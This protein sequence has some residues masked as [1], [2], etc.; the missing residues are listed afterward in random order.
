MPRIGSLR[1]DRDVEGLIRVLENGEDLDA[2]AAAESL[3]DLHALQAVPALMAALEGGPYVQYG[4]AEALGKLGD[5]RAVPALISV[6]ARGDYANAV[7]A[8]ALGLLGDPSA[9]APIAEALAGSGSADRARMAKALAALDARD[10]LLRIAADDGD[11]SGML[12]RWPAAMELA[13]LGDARVVDVL[14][15]MPM[16]VEE[17]EI[18]A[19]DVLGRL[20]DNRGLPF[21]L[22]RAGSVTQVVTV[23]LS[24]P[25]SEK[26]TW[27]QS[28][29]LRLAAVE[30]LGQIICRSAFPL[31]SALGSTG[32]ATM[33]PT[34]DCSAADAD[35]GGLFGLLDALGS[36]HPP[37]RGAAAAALAAVPAAYPWLLAALKDCVATR[38]AGA[39]DSLRLLKNSAAAA[40]LCMLLRDE[41]DPQVRVAAATALGAFPELGSTDELACEFAQQLK[42]NDNGNLRAQLAGELGLLRVRAIVSVLLAV[43]KDDRPGVRRVA[44]QALTG[45]A[46]GR[47][48]VPLIEVLHDESASVR[49]QA[50]RALGTLRSAD[51]VSPLIELL[52]DSS[53]EVAAAAAESLGQLG[54]FAAV[55]PLWEARSRP[56]RRL[57]RVIA[58][59]LGELLARTD[60]AA[61]Y[62]L[63]E[64][65]DLQ[66]QLMIIGVLTDHR[67][68][69]Y[70]RRLT[71]LTE[72]A[73]LPVALAAVRALGEIADP[74]TLQ[75]L[76]ASATR[77]SELRRAAVDAIGRIQ[78]PEATRILAT[79]FE[80][81]RFPDALHHAARVAL[82]AR[83]S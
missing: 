20:A 40:P 66:V 48:V 1:L 16:N 32:S 61:L 45:L 83:G 53:E 62:P 22:Q 65:T 49:A 25:Y 15:S 72:T 64:D 26:R 42:T 14:I 23:G 73:P 67:A 52:R 47:A 35:T 10:A 5:P 82:V 31:V 51:A 3:G 81:H 50:A 21:V 71:E 7:A 75:A 56:S 8:I 33:A 39:C 68:L 36:E 78:T 9:I 80:Q 43:L 13:R 60:A 24:G 27:R 46:D 44:I 28:D 54:S 69:A 76:Y 38:R 4:A 18:E 41:K 59:V 63:L 77:P 19:L 37:V 74:E 6:V 57:R 11:T 2:I 79:V 12:S 34:A 55:A 29:N 17:D 58:G 70:V 30:A